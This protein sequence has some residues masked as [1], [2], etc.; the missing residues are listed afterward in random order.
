MDYLHDH[1]ISKRL[2]NSIEHGALYVR[3]VCAFGVIP[4]IVLSVR[5]PARKPGLIIKTYFIKI[6]VAGSARKRALVY[7]EPSTL[8]SRPLTVETTRAINP[9]KII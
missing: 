5:P 6:R 2:S 1:A 7:L 3:H 8:R 9:G 4:R